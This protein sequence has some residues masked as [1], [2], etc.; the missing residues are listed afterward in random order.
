MSGSSSTCVGGVGIG[1]FST[2]V[3]SLIKCYLSGYTTIYVIDDE[4]IVFEMLFLVM[5]RELA[6]NICKE[7]VDVY[8]RKIAYY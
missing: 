2:R 5:V 1:E 6:D 7:A 8:I 4:E 3:T